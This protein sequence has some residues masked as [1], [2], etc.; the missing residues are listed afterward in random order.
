MTNAF[1]VGF[2]A[3]NAF[4]DPQSDDIELNGTEINQRKNLKLFFV[5]IM[6][7]YD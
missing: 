6:F 2:G 1:S 3:D 7:L 5:R 4:A